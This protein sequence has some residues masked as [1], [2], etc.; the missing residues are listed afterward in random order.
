MPYNGSLFLWHTAADLLVDLGTWKY[1]NLHISIFLK[2]IMQ[3]GSWNLKS[4]Q[5][6]LLKILILLGIVYPLFS[7]CRPEE[8]K[9]ISRQIG[10]DG[11]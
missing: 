5:E 7:L 1:L 8:T 2:K 4:A 3:P 10:L 6:Y 9:I 11:H